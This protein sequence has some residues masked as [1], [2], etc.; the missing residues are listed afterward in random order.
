MT[1]VGDLAQGIYY[2]KGLRS[3]NDITEDLYG[4]KATYIQLT[5]SYRSTVEIIDFASKALNAQNLGLKDA[6]PVL[7]HGDKPKVI[8]IKEKKEYGV[9]IDK[10]ID[11]VRRKGKKSIALI[12]KDIKECTDLAKSLKNNSK[13]EFELIK[14]KEKSITKEVVIL[15]SYLTKGL[16][17]DC[18]IIINP[19]Q[20]KYKENILDKR[21]LY[22]SLT[23]ALHYEY[24]IALE[25]MTN[26]I[27]K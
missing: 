5:Q 23:R 15:P 7:R 27:D 8:Q 25:E 20:N 24:I 19:S 9:E 3:W 26:L 18:C 2:Y 6:K 14:G 22:V 13:N 17:F 1:L 10:I 4:G 21:L 12:C 11:E 16:E